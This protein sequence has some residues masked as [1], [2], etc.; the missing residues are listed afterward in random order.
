MATKARRAIHARVQA[1]GCRAVGDEWSAAGRR[2]LEIAAELGLQPFQLRRWQ[3]WIQ[4]LSGL[5]C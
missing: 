4:G 3:T 5:S 2:I 1:G